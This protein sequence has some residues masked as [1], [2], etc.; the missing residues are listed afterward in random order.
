MY[1]FILVEEEKSKYEIY[2]KVH[3][4]A[5]K[6]SELKVDFSKTD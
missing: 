3:R 4:H 2:K 1:K 5:S 6:I